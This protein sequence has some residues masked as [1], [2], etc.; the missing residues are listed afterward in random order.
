MALRDS[1]LAGLARQ[2]GHPRGLAGRGVG[3]LRNRANGAT[4]RAAVDAPAPAPGQV[5][6]DIGFGGGVSL[7]PLLDRVGPSGR[8]HAVDIS[9]TMLDRARR[10]HRREAAA[11]RLVP[12][13]ASMADLPFADGSIDG[14]MTVNTVYFVPDDDLAGQARMSSPTGRLVL[15]FGDPVAMA[16]EPVTARGFRIRPVAALMAALAAAG[17]TVIDHRRVG[18][19]A[20]AT[21][22]LVAQPTRA[23]EEG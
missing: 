6:A 10:R 9:R 21:H 19:G 18:P 16:R 3:V 17:L 13:E 7:P 20:A 1:M 15:G 12:H 14:A 23:R 8:V 22:L 5:V 11:G 4:V 2:L